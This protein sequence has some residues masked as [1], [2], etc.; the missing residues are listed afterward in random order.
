MNLTHFFSLIVRLH[1]LRCKLF[2]LYLK[3]SVFALVIVLWNPGPRPEQKSKLGSWVWLAFLCS[4]YSRSSHT[5]DFKS[6][7][8][9]FLPGARQSW[10]CEGLSTCMCVVRLVCPLTAFNHS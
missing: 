3:H 2:L 7:I 10:K 6:N 4:I 9:N 5:K 8:R 1:R